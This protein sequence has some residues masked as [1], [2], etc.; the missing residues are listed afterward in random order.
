[1]LTWKLLRS[2]SLSRTESLGTG[3]TSLSTFW[4]THFLSLTAQELKA[5]IALS[6]YKSPQRICRCNSLSTERSQKAV[7]KSNAA[8]DWLSGCAAKAFR[9]FTLTCWINM[10]RRGFK[11][12]LQ[13]IPKPEDCKSCGKGQVKQKTW[14]AAS[15]FLLLHFW[16]QIRF[17]RHSPSAKQRANWPCKRKVTFDIALWCS[18]RPRISLF[19]QYHLQWDS[20]VILSCLLNPVRLYLVPQGFSRKQQFSLQ[21]QCC[22]G[23]SLKADSDLQALVLKTDIGSPGNFLIDKCQ[24]YLHQSLLLVQLHHTF[25]L[26]FSIFIIALLTALSS[27]QRA[28]QL[29]GGCSGD[30]PDCRGVSS[31]PRLYDFGLPFWPCTLMFYH[32]LCNTPKA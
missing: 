27:S 2:K 19:W 26:A 4:G 9:R 10:S 1:M 3:K 8:E 20:P 21:A 14:Q 11:K 31:L 6:A 25:V 18:W 32:W 29:R 28:V 30:I 17:S 15:S 13:W 24:L 23:S 16:R 22:Q 5:S 12:V 7:F